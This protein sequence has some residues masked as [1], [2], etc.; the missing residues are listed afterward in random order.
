MKAF[1]KRQ[2]N[3][4]IRKLQLP[5]GSGE[6]RPYHVI[7][8]YRPVASQSILNELSLDLKVL[9]PILFSLWSVAIE[10]RYRRGS[11]SLRVLH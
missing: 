10:V 2:S 6:G 7:Y 9:T 3:R 5:K 8:S 11:E 1:S 4:R